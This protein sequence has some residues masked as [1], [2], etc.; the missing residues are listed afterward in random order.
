MN[1]TAFFTALRRRGSGVFGTSLSQ[2]QVRGIEGI[3]DAFVSHGDGRAKTLAYALATAYHETA[4]RMVPVRETLAKD[5]ATARHRLR[6]ARYA[7]PEPPYGHAYYGR[8]QVQLTWKRN[9]ERSSEDAG[10]DLVRYPDKALDP[11]IGAR[12]LIRGLL[13]GRWNGRGFGIAHYLPDAR[14]D[15][16]KGARRTVNITDKWEVIAGYYR[17]FLM[18]IRNAGGVPR[19]TVNPASVSQAGFTERKC[20]LTSPGSKPDAAPRVVSDTKPGFRP[21]AMLLSILTL[22]FGGKR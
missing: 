9:Y 12:I 14:K 8:G 6:Q 18:A 16:L 15:D 11:V 17:S 5:D 19:D 2:Q 21:L 13:D 7:Q 4:R 10:V 20:G 1:R 22:V 3:L